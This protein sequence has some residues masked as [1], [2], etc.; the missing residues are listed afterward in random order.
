MLQRIENF[1]GLVILASD[2]KPDLDNSFF[3][4]FEAIIH[5]PMLNEAQRLRI[6]KNGFS[7]KADLTNIDLEN[8][9]MKYELSGAAIMNVIRLVSLDAIRNGTNLIT[10]KG[11]VMGI[12]RELLKEGMRV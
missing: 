2:L 6:W 3:R 7:P 11:V 9:A 4:R 5:F 1:N 8:L 10:Q 12:R